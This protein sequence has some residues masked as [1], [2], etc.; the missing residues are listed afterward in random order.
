MPR[1][2]ESDRRKKHIASLLQQ[3]L[4]TLC[5]DHPR[6]SDWYSSE[7]R[8]V[9]VFITD[10]KATYRQRPW[11]DMRDDDLKEL[12]EHPAGFIVFILGDD[13]RYLVIPARDLVA[14]LPNHRE[15]LLE[16]G[17]YHFNTVLGRRAFEQLP[18]WDYSQYL[19]K[20]GLIP[21]KAANQSLH[22]TPR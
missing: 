21:Q 6:R 15:G 11:F 3:H 19:G 4:G 7:D 13:T 12:A 2:P 17:F 18:D 1:N 5:L 8:T 22:S 16:T 14:Q 20:V 10:S 9:D